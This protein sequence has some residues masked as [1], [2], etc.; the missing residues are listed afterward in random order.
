MADED[1]DFALLENLYCNVLSFGNDIPLDY[2]CVQKGPHVDISGH[3]HKPLS[4][5]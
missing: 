3:W 2:M 1:R 5:A 4:S